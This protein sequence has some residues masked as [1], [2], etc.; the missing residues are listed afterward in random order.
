MAVTLELVAPSELTLTA[1]LFPQG[2]DTAAVSGVTLTERSTSK[3]VYRGTFTAGPT[4]LHRVVVWSGTTPVA[5]TWAFLSGAD[6]TAYAADSAAITAAVIRSALGLASANLDTQ[7]DALPT[8]SET[9]SAV[10]SNLAA[11]LAHIDANISSRSTVT[12]GDIPAGLTAQQVWEYVTR[13]LTETVTPD[14]SALD[15]T[16]QNLTAQVTETNERIVFQVPDGPVITL[17]AP[18]AGQTTAWTVCYD[19]HGVAEA[20]VSIQVKLYA[21]IQGPGAA[22][23]GATLTATSGANGVASLQLPRNAALRFKCRRGT[24]PW[25]AF[26]GV[27]AETLELPLLIG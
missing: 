26:S 10:R 9:A 11:E 20:G 8:A 18:V 4:G 15:T 13:G 24:G 2:S 6:E 14:L 22:Y 7:L 17:A 25:I 21:G 16:L 23:D 19:E 1:S 5:V 3:G 27:D 12:V